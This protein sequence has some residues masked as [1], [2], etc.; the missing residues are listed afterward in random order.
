[1]AIFVER[2]KYYVLKS[3][4]LYTGLLFLEAALNI[5]SP[6]RQSPTSL[7]C[8]WSLWFLIAVRWKSR[9]RI[10]L[11]ATMKTWMPNESRDLDVAVVLELAVIARKRREKQ[12]KRETAPKN[13]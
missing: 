8:L 11:A 5:A 2:I 4:K 12:R 9:G 6:T 1:M 10:I 7:I 13:H 3:F